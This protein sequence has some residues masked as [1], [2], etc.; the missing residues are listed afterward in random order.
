MNYIIKGACKSVIGNLRQNN[1]DNY[2]FNGK[3][4][5][6]KNNGTQG[7]LI[8][9]FKNDENITCSVFDGMGGEENGERASFLATNTLKEYI[10]ENTGFSWKQYIEIANEKICVEMQENK[11]MGT[12]MATVV[13]T[14]NKVYICNV[15]DSRIYGIKEGKIEQLSEDHTEAKLQERLNIQSNHKARLTQHLGIRKDE[16]VIV[17]YTNEYQYEEYNKFLLCSDG[18]TDMLTD[19][20]IQSI[21]STNISVDQIVNKLVEE[22]LNKGGIDNTTVIVLEIEKQ[23]EEIEK[24]EENIENNNIVTIAKKIKEKFMGERK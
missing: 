16:L 7:I 3:I 10:E 17:P 4:L 20:E 9:Q 15:G 19:C 24:L 23:K 11:H 18:L 5:P 21:L 14:E 1:E 8:T 2:Y 6:E 12:T 22:A 13:F